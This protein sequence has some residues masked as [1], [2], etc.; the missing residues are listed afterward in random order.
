MLIPGVQLATI[1]PMPALFH[2]SAKSPEPAD[3]HQINR[4]MKPWSKP[5]HAVGFLFSL[6][7]LEKRQQGMGNPPYLV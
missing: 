3:Y 5:A 2:H 4:P 1:V 6:Q 7:S